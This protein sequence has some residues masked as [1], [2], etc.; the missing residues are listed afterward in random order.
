MNTETHGLS[1]LGVLLVRSVF[2]RVL[3]F[4]SAFGRGPSPA[5]AFR[6]YVTAIVH[7]FE[8]NFVHCFVG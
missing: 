2:I 4:S 7:A 6:A 1:H 5:N 3:L 8:V